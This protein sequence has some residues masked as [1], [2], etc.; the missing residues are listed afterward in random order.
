MLKLN[1]KFIVGAILTMVIAPST[2]A[3]FLSSDFVKLNRFVQTTNSNDN[4]MKSFRA[5]RDLIEGEKWEQ[6]EKRFRDFLRDYPK[7]K[8]SDAAIY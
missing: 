2:F 7:H 8:E 1:S 3:Q 4:A 5:G 6:A